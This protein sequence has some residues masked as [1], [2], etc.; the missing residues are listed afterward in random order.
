[1]TAVSGRK[2]DGFFEYLDK[3]QESLNKNI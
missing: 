3:M 2:N 1:M